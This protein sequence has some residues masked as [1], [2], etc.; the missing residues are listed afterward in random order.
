MS[1]GHSG[2]WTRSSKHKSLVNPETNV[3]FGI[4]S[5]Q[6]RLVRHE[7]AIMDIMETVDEMDFGPI[8][9]SASGSPEYR[10]VHLRGRFLD[11]PAEVK[12]GD[13]LQ[14]AIGYLNSYDGTWGERL[15]L[16]TFRLVC[17]NGAIASAGKRFNLSAAHLGQHRPEEML[18]TLEDSMNGF[19]HQITQYRAWVDR[20]LQIAHVEDTLD[21]IDL[22]KR[23]QSWGLERVDEEPGMDLWGF[24]NTMTAVITHNVQSLDRRV[25]SWRKLRKVQSTW[26]R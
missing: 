14:P 12:V 11:R 4:V 23:D 6:Y 8:E 10:R 25:N 13:L 5:D 24:Y 2:D 22:T 21:V 9:W 7:E 19:D 20:P 15:W 17:S 3:L 16:E 26:D 1:F 18:A